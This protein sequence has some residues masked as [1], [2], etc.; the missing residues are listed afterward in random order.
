M[1]TETLVQVA[2]VQFRTHLDNVQVSSVTSKLNSRKRER[3]AFAT[4]GQRV[5][6]ANFQLEMERLESFFLEPS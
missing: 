3:M 1:F 4:G 2:L 5:R 6:C